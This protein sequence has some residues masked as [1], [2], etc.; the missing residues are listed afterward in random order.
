M[1]VKQGE[2]P[3]CANSVLSDGKRR[4]IAAREAPP[5]PASHPKAKPSP[6][7]LRPGNWKS[8]KILDLFSGYDINKKTFPG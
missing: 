1:F 6:G 3:K 2:L 4:L 8:G 7:R 5:A